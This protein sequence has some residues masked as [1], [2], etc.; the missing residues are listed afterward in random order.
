MA[1]ASRNY[2]SMSPIRGAHQSEHARAHGFPCNYERGPIVAYV[3]PY[4]AIHRC[5][6]PAAALEG[7]YRAASF[8]AHRYTRMLNPHI[9]FVQL[10]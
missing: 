1:Q 8:H 7:Q 2:G 4:S 10:D 5:E 6:S 9:R 3:S